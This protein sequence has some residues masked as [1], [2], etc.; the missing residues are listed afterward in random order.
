VSGRADC[1]ASEVASSIR[2]FNFR[3]GDED[4]LQ[5]GLAEA[6][7]TAGFEVRREVRLSAGDRIDLL[8][9]RVGVEVKVA[10][11]A[12]RVARQIARYAKHD[13]AGLVLVT[14]KL[15]HSPPSISM[16]IEVVCLAG[17]SL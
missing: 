13:L 6:L 5:E 11:S 1:S 15:R 10:G 16:P 12:A 14:N 7:T 9:G 2:S 17:A 4:Q 8:V 3:Y